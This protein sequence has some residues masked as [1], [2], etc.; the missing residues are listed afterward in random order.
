MEVLIEAGGTIVMRNSLRGVRFESV[1]ERNR[2][3]RNLTC[4]PASVS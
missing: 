1:A 4:A 2:N 3:N